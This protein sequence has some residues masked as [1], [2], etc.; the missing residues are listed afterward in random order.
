MDKNNTFDNEYFNNLYFET[1]VWWKKYIPVQLPYQIRLKRVLRGSTL[2][3][4]CGLGRNLK[5]L[6]SGSIG[7]DHNPDS[8]LYCQSNNL[9][10]HLSDD[11]H[12]KFSGDAIKPFDN[13]L[14][15]HVLEHIELKDQIPVLNEFLPYLRDDGRIFIITPQEKGFKSTE[16]HISWTDFDRVSHVL[17]NLNSKISVIKMSSFPLPRRFGI[18]FKY[19]EFNVVAVKVRR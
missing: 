15:S 9:P 6:G 10:V 19:N 8:V 11:F 7:V 12:K 4:G 14:I 17:E 13:L 1:T 16:S 3:I 2:D 18:F 5:H